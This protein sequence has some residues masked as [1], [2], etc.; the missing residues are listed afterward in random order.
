MLLKLMMSPAG[1]AVDRAMVRWTGTSPLCHAFA[2]GS[3]FP[4]RPAL[5]LVVKGRR[6]GRKRASVL[7]YFEIDGRLFVVGSRG[8]GPS[9][10]Q[11]VTNLRADPEA[12]I[13]IRRKPR[14]VR[15]RI[16]AD[17]ERKSL[18]TELV[19]LVP[20]YAEYQKLTTRE[21]PLVIFD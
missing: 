5:L 18:W 13:F 14:H 3:G 10:P 1:L 4:P 7:P 9:D 8:G 17:N 15:A 2:R 20:T 19:K 6:T 16:A 12:T 21:I 11:W